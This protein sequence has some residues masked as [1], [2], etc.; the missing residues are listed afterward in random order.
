[1]SGD[2]LD[3]M[4]YYALLGVQPQASR[5]EIRAAFHRFALKYHPDNHAGEPAKL[6]RATQV[7]RRGAEAYRVLGDATSRAT[8]DKGLQG[9]KLRL[10]SG[11]EAEA[12][13]ARSRPGAS[14]KTVK[15][16]KAR[17]FW[18]KAQRAIKAKDWQQAKLNIG[19]ALMHEPDSELLKERQAFVQE[20]LNAK[21]R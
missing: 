7:F 16:L 19:I 21:K 1:M 20:Q 8:Y 15:S 12:T 14:A 10:S 17:P 2:P 9:G 13:S 6:R 5:D 3:K 18:T 11:D 4:S